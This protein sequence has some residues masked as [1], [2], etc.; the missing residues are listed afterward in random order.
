MLAMH[1]LSAATKPSRKSLTMRTS[2]IAL[3]TIRPR[4]RSLF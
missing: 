3:Q 4:L 1:T 2:S